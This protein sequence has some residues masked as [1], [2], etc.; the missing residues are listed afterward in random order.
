MIASVT[1]CCGTIGT[2]VC[3]IERAGHS[4]TSDSSIIIMRRSS[5][6]TV[7]VAS[8]YLFIRSFIHSCR[9]AL[10]RFFATFL[11][12]YCTGTVPVPY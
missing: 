6:N 12:E 2:G 11:Y 10:N 5:R 9:R 7:F 8:I 1:V 4:G 3:D